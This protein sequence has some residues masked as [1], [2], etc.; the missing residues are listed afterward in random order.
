MMNMERWPHGADRPGSI[1]IMHM[2]ESMRMPCWKE[3]AHDAKTTAESYVFA[4][5]SSQYARMGK[6]SDGLGGRQESIQMSQLLNRRVSVWKQS[7]RRVGD[8]TGRWSRWTKFLTSQNDDR[9]KS[10]TNYLRG[11]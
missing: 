11:C 3:K 10:G 4:E 6:M 8:S 1:A 7:P 5:E 9:V 2:D